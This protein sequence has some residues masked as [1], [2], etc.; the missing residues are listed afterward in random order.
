MPFVIYL[1]SFGAAQSDLQKHPH[2]CY[3]K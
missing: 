3:C 2:H 1:C